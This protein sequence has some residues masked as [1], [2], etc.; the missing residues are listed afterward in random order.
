[1]NR[2]TC[3]SV[4]R[5]QP[6]QHASRALNAAE[7]D[8]FAST[9]AGALMK[10]VYRESGSQQG[11]PPFRLCDGCTTKNRGN[12]RFGSELF[13]TVNFVKDLVAMQEMT[14]K[15]VHPASNR[16][17]SPVGPCCLQQWD[18]RL[19]VDR[20]ASLSMQTMALTLARNA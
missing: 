1:M 20:N 8:P 11:V 16:Q 4:G 2:P 7:K 9:R 14:Q 10:M 3:R 15:A 13:T 6:N 5:G 19:E 17:F 18:S 12:Q